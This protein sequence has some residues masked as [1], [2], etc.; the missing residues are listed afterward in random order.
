MPEGPLAV[1]RELERADEEIGAA[2]AGLERL[3]GEVGEIRFEVGELQA[4]FTGLQAERERRRAEVERARGEVADAERVLAEAGEAVRT[5]KPD[6]QREAEL[7]AVRARDRLS[8]AERRAAEAGKAA[9]DLENRVGEATA[10]SEELHARARKLAAE[11]S[12][13]RRIAADAGNEPG[14]GLEGVQA[15]SEVARA[16]LFVAQGQLTVER[17]AVI[18]QAN[19]VG[20]LALG[21]PLTAMGTGALARRVEQ[22]LG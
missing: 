15:W 14:P 12:A 6:A 16:A 18:R 10:Q 9:G 1:L 3:A 11:L 2:L 21:E 4:F 22:A 8:V 13:M 19:E 20:A 7:F 5:V 17:E